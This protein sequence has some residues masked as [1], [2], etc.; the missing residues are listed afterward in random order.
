MIRKKPEDKIDFKKA[1]ENKKIPILTLDER[2]H[3]LFPEYEKTSHIKEHEKKLN[4]LIKQQGK[5]ISEIKEMK[6]LKKKL[7]DEIVNN[8]DAANLDGNL[9]KIKKQEKSQKLIKELNDK[10]RKYDEE[11]IELPYNI[12]QANEKLMMESMKICYQRLK[13]NEE[14]IAKNTEWIAK[15]REELKKRIL[16]K[17]DLEMKN[18]AIYSYMHDLLGAEAIQIFDNEEGKGK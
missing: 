13:L 4:N 16:I 12:K 5:E 2:W 3:Q 15:V 8:M 7:M 9:L 1:F 17:Q 18:T 10:I 14:E 6:K 11:L